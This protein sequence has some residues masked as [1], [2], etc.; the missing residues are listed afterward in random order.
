MSSL[1]QIQANRRNAQRSTGPVTEDGKRRSGK[2]V[3]G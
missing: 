1:R 2:S 3:T